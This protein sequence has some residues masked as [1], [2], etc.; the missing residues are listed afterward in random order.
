MDIMAQFEHH[1]CAAALFVAIS[2]GAEIYLDERL[3][4]SWENMQLLFHKEIICLPCK[5]NDLYSTS[6]SAVKSIFAMAMR[7]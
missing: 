7:R 6:F 2:G 4:L 5:Q 1:C 3:E